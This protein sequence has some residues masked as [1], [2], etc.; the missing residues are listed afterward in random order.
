MKKLLAILTM[1]VLILG[2]SSAMAADASDALPDLR[3]GLPTLQ[4]G[5]PSILAPIPDPA[6][7]LGSTGA[8]YQTGYSYNGKTYDLYLYSKPDTADAFIAA[9]TK[10]ADEAGYKVT[11]GA[12]AGNDALYITEGD[13]KAILLYDYQ[14]YMML[15]VPDGADF[16]LRETVKPT[17]V[18]VVRE[19][20]M[21]LDYNGQHYES[22]DQGKKVFNAKF[23]AL[24]EDKYAYQAFAFEQPCPVSSIML[25][26][27]S[28]AQAGDV[29]T[30]K[31]S[32][33]Q[34]SREVWPRSD[35]YV[36]L[37]LDENR[38]VSGG[39]IWDKNYMYASDSDYFTL[40]ITKAEK[41]SKGYLMEGTFEGSFSAV[42]TSGFDLKTVEIKN[43]FFSTYVE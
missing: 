28:N 21:T 31:K 9:Y 4:S 22:L 37:S 14:G 1:L 6:E 26:W 33:G 25:E 10:A 11:K 27:P 13:T 7:S 29:F 5:L 2:C 41:T 24:G 30:V 42:M 32:D 17:P 16:V 23:V 43:G 20:Y 15:M 8:A 18:P 34:G 40:T 12:E 35:C 3:D 39:R 36:G 38:V 19:N